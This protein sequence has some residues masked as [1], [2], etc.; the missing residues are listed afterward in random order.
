MKTQTSWKL[1]LGSGLP[2]ALAIVIG[3][4]VRSQSA[5]HGEGKMMNGKMMERCHGMHKL[6]QKLSED[7]KAQDIELTE[8]IA[9]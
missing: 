8:Q 3:T 1:F 7:T 2:L 9:K 6:K 4:P 5:E